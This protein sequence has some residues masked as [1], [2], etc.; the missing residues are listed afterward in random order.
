MDPAVAIALKLGL[1]ALIQLWATHTNKPAGW[2]PSAEDWAA[3]DA[4]VDA[5]T[6]EAR[7]ALAQLRAAQFNG[8]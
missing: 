8:N 5:A 2:K 3:L 6:P 4:E 1:E 7:L